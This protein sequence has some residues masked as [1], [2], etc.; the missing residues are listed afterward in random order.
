MI[1]V[2]H[3]RYEGGRCVIHF[4]TDIF[5][6]LLAQ[7]QNLGMCY[8]KCKRGDNYQ[9]E[10]LSL[11]QDNVL[12]GAYYLDTRIPSLLWIEKR[13]TSNAS[14]LNVKWPPL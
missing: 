5:V 11:V 7:S 8:M 9:I 6:F 3:S 13:M 2:L 14:H 4:D 10:E 12:P 1:M